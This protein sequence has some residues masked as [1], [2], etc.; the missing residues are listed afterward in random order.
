[1]ATCGDGYHTGQCRSRHFVTEGRASPHPSQSCRMLH[2]VAG[3]FTH[4]SSTEGW[5]SSLQSSAIIISATANSPVQCPFTFSPVYLWRR[6]TDMELLGQWVNTTEILL[7]VA[8]FLSI[9]SITYQFHQDFLKA[10]T[11]S[12]E[13]LS[14][15]RKWTRE[16]SCSFSTVWWM[17]GEKN[18]EMKW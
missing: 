5:P 17:L 10:T 15:I 12:W 18:K 11:F 2:C 14:Y 7:N 13:N 1:M 8:K 16:Q 4:Q 6:Y 9:G 3:Q